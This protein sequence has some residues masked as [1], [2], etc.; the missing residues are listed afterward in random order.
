MAD[1]STGTLR[2]AQVATLLLALWA[3]PFCTVAHIAVLLALKTEISHAH[4][5]V[6]RADAATDTVVVR[7]AHLEPLGSPLVHVASLKRWLWLS[8]TTG[9]GLFLIAELDVLV[10]ALSR[11]ATSADESTGSI[12]AAAT[13]TAAG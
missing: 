1:L 5:T 8:R 6:W 9:Y 12:A 13:R 3:L 11:V 2:V 10:H 7:G 4:W